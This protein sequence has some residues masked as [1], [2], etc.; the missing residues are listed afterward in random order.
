MRVELRRQLLTGRR[1][2]N[3]SVCVAD[4]AYCF[5][6]LMSRHMFDVGDR[7]LWRVR[8][9]VDVCGAL[10]D[11]LS[12]PLDLGSRRVELLLGRGDLGREVGE[13]LRGLVDLRGRAG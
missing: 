9:P 4:S 12:E 5:A 7:G 13:S 11:D 1:S 3:L 10:A 6:A 2:S 8:M